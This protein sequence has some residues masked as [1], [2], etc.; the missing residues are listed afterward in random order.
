MTDTV[1][2]SGVKPFPMRREPGRPFDPHPD[3]AEYRAQGELPKV[4]CP[5]GFDAYLITDYR[6][7]R[8]VLANPTVSSVAASS[9][10]T[11]RGHDVTKPMGAG[12][13][14]QLDGAEHARMRE[15]LTPEFTVRRMRALREYI[16][17][18]INQHIDA[19]LA[20]GPGPVDF[21]DEFA[22]PIPALVICEMLGV[23]PEDR[24]NFQRWAGAMMDTDLTREQQN[25]PGE[26]MLGSWRACASRRCKIPMRTP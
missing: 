12:N 19:M 11:Q 25:G 14:I 26:E 2:A 5:A 20:H 9:F 23:P 8:E 6:R 1:D 18:I 13:I 22:V 4:S 10:H 7:A 24:K 17:E 21:V 15:L 3:Y 16:Q